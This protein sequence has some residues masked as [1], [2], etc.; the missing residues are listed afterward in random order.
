MPPGQHPS[1]RSYLCDTH[2]WSATRERRGQRASVAATVDQKI[3]DWLSVY[4]DGSYSRRTYRL[5]MTQATG[6]MQV[7]TTNAF[8]VSPPVATLSPCS[9][10]PGAPLCEQV[11]YSFLNDAG[12]NEY[13]YG[14]SEY[15]EGTLGVRVKLGGDWVLDADGTAGRDHDRAVDPTHALNNGALNAALASSDPKTAFNPFGGG[16]SPAVINSVLNARILA[17]GDT[18]PQVLEAK[19]DGP[20]VR[21]PGGQL[22][23][24][25]GVQWQHDELLYG[26]NSG[27]EGSP[28]DASLRQNLNRHSTA[29][30]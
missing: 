29:E 10:A 9:P 24:A 27:I 14:R 18:G 2:G 8:F 12:P 28:T 16:N 20:V 5:A 21:L 22:R 4:G 11:D 1:W 13:N 23:A 25:A 30:F 7:P 3:N 26:F 17:P 19:A 6:P 15:Y